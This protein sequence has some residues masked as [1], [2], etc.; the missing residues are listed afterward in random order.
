MN[1]HLT[2]D[3]RPSSAP[4]S[5]PV[6]PPGSP[7]P[8][9]RGEPGT[10][11]PVPG[12]VGSSAAGNGSQTPAGGVAAREGK[13]ETLRPSAGFH[14]RTWMI[15]L[16]AGIQILSLNDRTH[17]RAR[18]RHGQVI[19]D[20]AITMVR[21][22]KVP[23][24]ER[25]AITVEYQPPDR[26]RRDPDNISIAGKYAIDGITAAGVLKG[27]DERHVASVTCQIGPTYPRGRLVL[28]ITEVTA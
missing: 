19:K 20:A 24:L 3:A 18:N 4:S 1:G 22:A 23:A 17:W 2:Q 25:V 7:V 12:H 21:K 8:P 9:R 14:P 13:P 28:Y 11:S 5:A 27:D 6:A 16:P 26:R 15:E 10:Q